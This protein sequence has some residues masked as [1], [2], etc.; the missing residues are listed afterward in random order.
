MASDGGGLFIGPYMPFLGVTLP[1]VVRAVLRDFERDILDGD[2]FFTNDPWVGVGHA[3]DQALVAPVIHH[4]RILA[5]V[6][7][8]LHDL[9]VGAATPFTNARAGDAFSEGPLFPPIKLVDRGRLDAALERAITRNVRTP[10]LNRL[11]IRARMAALTAGRDRILELAEEYGT[12]AIEGFIIEMSQRIREAVRTRLVEFP[13]GTWSDEVFI[14]HDGTSPLAIYRIN[15]CL[16]KSG[17]GLSFDFTESDGLAPG[18]INTTRLGL[19]GGILAAVMSCLCYDMNWC[20]A[21]LAGVVDVVCPPNRI[22][23]AAPPAAVGLAT[24]TSIPAAAAVARSC[25]SKMMALANGF[26]HRAQAYSSFGQTGSMIYGRDGTGNLRS[27][28]GSFLV[29]RGAGAYADRDGLDTGGS[30]GTPGHSMFN[31]EVAEENNPLLLV[32]FRRELPETAGHGERRGGAGMELGLVAR[33]GASKLFV[34]WG[35]MNF[36]HPQVKGIFGGL[37]ASVAMTELLR[38]SNVLRVFASGVVPV[39][40]T[41]IEFLAAERIEAKAVGIEMVEGDFLRVV[42]EGGGGYGDPLDRAVEAVAT[43][44]QRGA[45][46]DREAAE[47][48]GAVFRD[49]VPD[50]T[51]TSARRES[52]R[53]D[54]V[55]GAFATQQSIARGSSHAT[56][57]GI[58]TGERLKTTSGRDTLCVHC[59]YP[60]RGANGDSRLDVVIRRVDIVELNSMNRSAFDSGQIEISELFC[61]GCGRRLD[62][63]IRRP[64]DPILSS[65]LG[66]VR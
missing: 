65:S 7:A 58:A 49:G 46:T 2:M 64:L 63:Q 1:E 25:L 36:H 60:V 27:T 21:A 20:P 19:T 13:D 39:K 66:Q 52:I 48:Y 57:I 24:V 17:D 62:L 3:F 54:R 40:R 23:T 34:N 37:P 16:T 44:V 32:V 6:G 15:C 4:D 5:W 22:V 55:G 45:I 41:D 59:S 8:C 30:P 51:A 10:E 56:A 18:P 12:A 47:I 33:S 43:D 31:V 29:G 14:D 26:A 9:D 11:N 42:V 61:R 50:K 35:S 53:L 28:P 38:G